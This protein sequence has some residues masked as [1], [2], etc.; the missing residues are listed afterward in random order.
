MQ[1]VEKDTLVDGVDDRP[2]TDDEI[3]KQVKFMLLAMQGSWTTQH[4]YSWKVQNSMY[5]EDCKGRV[6]MWRPN[7]DDTRRLMCRSETLTNR[8]MFLIG[9]MALDAEHCF[10]W[11]LHRRMSTIFP[12]MR[13]HGC[14]NDC[15]F[16]TGVPHEQIEYALE[17]DC[18]PDEPIPA[19]KSYLPL[20]AGRLSAL[21]SQGRRLTAA[22]KL[23]WSHRWNRPRPSAWRA[24]NA[25]TRVDR[26]DDDD[27]VAF[28]YWST[29]GP[30]KSEGWW[31]LMNEPEEIGRGPDDT[32]QNEVADAIVKNRG[33]YVDG[34]GG[35]GKSYLI[36]L[37][38]E[39]FEADGFVDMVPNKK[40]EFVKKSR[41]H[42]VAFTHVASQNI[43]GQTLLHELHRHARSKRLVIIVDEAGLVPLS[44]WSLSA[45]PEIHGQYR[46]RSRRF[47][48]T[49]ARYPG[50]ALGREMRDF[51]K[52]GFMHDLCDGLY[53][54]LQRYQARRRLRSL[55]L[56]GLDLPEARHRTRRRSGDG[57]R[58]ISGTRRALL[59]HDSVPHASMSNRRQ[60]RGE[61]GAGSLQRGA[62]ARRER[63]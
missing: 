60:R 19:Q 51:P 41:V 32:F 12:A 24:R 2:Y 5:D 52:S 13:F 20:L 48:R 25:R 22:P 40:G 53:V 3:R 56:R 4:H 7:A 16:V 55:L 14:I 8:T 36:K 28:G 18:K 58:A 1:S 45:E 29:N 57:P 59:R 10:V 6:Y 17:H 31:K 27:D 21:Q 34:R 15:L 47:R 42:C 63:E 50:S 62:R 33:G 9:R 54:Q 23:E 44:M 30:F 39:K 46:R 37:L 61:Q 26:G 38:V 11:Q 43:E 49:T 35:T